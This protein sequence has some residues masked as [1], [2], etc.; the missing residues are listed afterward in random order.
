MH[1]F[2]HGWRRKAGVVTLVMALATLGLWV[3]SRVTCDSLE[4]HPN[5][6]SIFSIALNKGSIELNHHLEEARS[7]ESI[8]RSPK[9]LFAWSNYAADGDVPMDLWIDYGQWGYLAIET[10]GRTSSG[11]DA[12]LRVPYLT[13]VIA[14]TLLSVYLI[15]YKAPKRT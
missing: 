12:Y 9:S 2:I 15:F 13:S 14:L 5:D 6:T 1:T 3:R 10:P 8:L 11:Q 7:G 4:M